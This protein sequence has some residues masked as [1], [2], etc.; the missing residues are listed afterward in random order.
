VGFLSSFV[1]RVGGAFGIKGAGGAFTN[2]NLGIAAAVAGTAY[3]GYAL[4]GAGAAAPAAAETGLISSAGANIAG[5]APVTAGT[6]LSLGTIATAAGSA[7]KAGSEVAGLVTIVDS[8]TG[9][10][11]RIANTEAVPA[12]WQVVSTPAAVAPAA[13]PV[14]VSSPAAPVSPTLLLGL[15]GVLV[16][17]IAM[18]R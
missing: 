6:S 11:K 12:G 4:L 16:L 15:G 7:L 10:A 5:F 2:K 9:R 1:D 17:L 14:V 8:L 18:R 13:A 3:G